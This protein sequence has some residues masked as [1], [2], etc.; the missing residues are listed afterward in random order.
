MSEQTYPV[1]VRDIVISDP[2]ILPV[3]EMGLYFV[4][5][6]WLDQEKFPEVDG[7]PSFYAFESPDLIHWSR[8][9]KVFEKG[10][11]WADLDYWAPE[12]HYY[13]GK[14]YLVSSFRAS[15]TYRRCQFLRSDSPR[16]PFL[17]IEEGPVTP[18]GWHCLDGTLYIDRKNQPWMVFCH[19]WLQVNDGQICAVPLSED[20]GH[21]IGD[22]IILFRGT[23]APWATRKMI[24]D[25][26]CGYVTDGPWLHRLTDGTLIMLWSNYSDYGY[27]T[28]YAVSR[29][30]EIY[31]PWDQVQMPLYAMDGAHSMLFRTFE[32]QLMMCL[33][34]NNDYKEKRIHLFEMEEKGNR[35]HIINE[36]TG[37]WYNSIRGMGERYRYQEPCIEEPAFTHLGKMGRRF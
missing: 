6:R 20:L 11:F 30:G 18:E 8:P 33:H 13:R 37:N 19:E 36:V 29:Y 16:G 26:D 25:G 27:T 28:G 5:A 9:Y 7:S 1:F 17:P 21:A 2:C 24:K 32:G 22:P 15:G 35:I 31:G 12:A 10:D 4:Y 34:C 23:D 3:K 14:Y